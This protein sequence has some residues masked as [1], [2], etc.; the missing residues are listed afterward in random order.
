MFERGRKDRA[1][2]IQQVEL[3]PSEEIPRA[4]PDSL[5]VF[6]EL[7]SIARKYR[8]RRLEQVIDQHR[9]VVQA[10]RDLMRAQEEWLIA[11]E[12]LKPDNL[13]SIRNAERHKVK[14]EEAERQ[15]Q[16]ATAL[17][18][19]AAFKKETEIEDIERDARRYEAQLRRNQARNAYLGIN[20]K[21]E[22]EQQEDPETALIHL[23]EELSALAQ[24][25]EELLQSEQS[26]EVQ[27][28]SIDGKISA[29]LRRKTRLEE[30]LAAV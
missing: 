6:G 16:L 30:Q 14:A 20:A 17:R 5:T 7:T 1:L 11:K 2:V 28:G 26:T 18:K 21:P 23:A 9:A 24:E 22:E 12:R 3:S 13:E 15:L 29:L 27:V 25:R 10:H 19:I 8:L 4:Y